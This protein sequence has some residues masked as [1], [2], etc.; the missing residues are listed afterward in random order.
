MPNPGSYQETHWR[1]AILFKGANDAIVDLSG[2]SWLAEM[3]ALDGSSVFKWKSVGAITGEGTI[4]TASASTGVIVLDATEAQHAAVPA[5]V[6]YTWTLYDITTPSDPVYMANGEAFVGV[7]GATRTVFRIVET[8]G[9][10]LV[11]EMLVGPPGPVGPV[12]PGVIVFPTKVAA[13]ADLNWPVLTQA[14]VVAD[15]IT[16]VDGIYQKQGLVGSG[17]WLRV[18]DLPIP[19]FDIVNGKIFI[20]GDGQS[21]MQNEPAYTWTPPSNL[22]IWNN[23]A[24]VEDVGTAFQTVPGDKIGLLKSIGAVVARRYPNCKVY[25]CRSAFGGRAVRHWIGG[26]RYTFSSSTTMGQP[27]AAHVRFNSATPGLITQ[28]VTSVLDNAGAVRYGSTWPSYTSMRFEKAGDPSTFI[29]LTPGAAVYDTSDPFHPF[30][31]VAVSAVTGSGGTLTDSDELVI[32]APPDAYTNRKLN[33]IA[34]A[35]AAGV[36]LT[37]DFEVWSQGESDTLAQLY[38]PA[39]YETREAR[40]LTDGLIDRGTATIIWGCSEYVVGDTGGEGLWIQFNKALQRVAQA[41]PDRR[42][43]IRTSEIPV[44]FWEAP[45]S[46]NLHMTAAGY[47]MAGRLFANAMYSGVHRATS[48]VMLQRPGQAVGEFPA[49]DATTPP[50]SFQ[51]LTGGFWSTSGQIGI[52]FAGDVWRI[53]ATGLALGTAAAPAQALEIKRTGTGASANVGQILSS[54]EYIQTIAQ[55]LF[56]NNN[57]GP[58]WNSF[59]ARGTITAPAVVQ[60]N[61]AAFQQDANLYT[62]AAFTFSARHQFKIIEPTP[63][64]SALGGE[65]AWSLASLGTATLTEKFAFNGQQIRFQGAEIVNTDRLFMPRISTRQTLPTAT[66][67]NKGI[68]AVANPEAGKSDLVSNVSG[69]TWKYMDGTTVSLV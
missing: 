24:S 2:R 46:L 47:E 37:P 45:I 21:N 12:G 50:L 51:G 8:F 35:A 7:P 26:V 52:A 41:H 16:A 66:T 13:D 56:A 68:G 4:D 30:Y 19:P 33:Q 58:S 29:T 69:G 42:I 36:R 44:E 28:F 59:K 14:W 25:L 40:L 64:T 10:T 49:G 32:T 65:Y 53:S 22:Y 20:V 63:S 11:G 43:Y 1:F 27:S 5:G 60:Q 62:G 18:G 3:F 15:P 55:R 38:Y 67:A 34:A 6:H 61:D 48:P 54:G 31:T 17:S 9:N 39:D 23:T 57:T